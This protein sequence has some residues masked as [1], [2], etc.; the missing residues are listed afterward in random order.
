M[1]CH[2]SPENARQLEAQQLRLLY[3]QASLALIGNVINALVVA[4]TLWDVVPHV[5][6]LTWLVVIE[7]ITLA[8][9][10]LARWYKQTP[11]PEI[12]QQRWRKLFLLGSCASGVLWGSAGILLFPDSSRIHQMFLMFMLGGMAAGG[13]GV[14]SAIKSVYLSYCLSTLLPILFRVFLNGGELSYIMGFVLFFFICIVLISGKHVHATIT[15]A[16]RLRVANLDLIQHLSAA[17]EQAEHMNSELAASH[18]ALSESHER[19]RQMFERNHA[20]QLLIDPESGQIMDANTAAAIFYGGN[21]EILK[22]TNITNINTLPREQVVAEMQQAVREQRPYFQFRHRL[23]SGAIR[24]VEVHASPVTVGGKTLVYSIIH[25]VTARK[26]AEAALRLSEERFR[27]LIEHA[28]D[29]ITIVDANGV[30]AY[31]SPSLKRLLGY[32]EESVIGKPTPA[33][34]HPADEPTV[35]T[36]FSA[37]VEEPMGVRAF[38]FR[39]RHRDG[40]WRTFESIAQNL[41]DDNA[42]AGVVLNSRDITERKEIERL[43][44]DLVATVSH[45]LRTPLTSLRGFA[46]LLLTR[47]F[48]Q[49]KQRQFLSVIVNEATR[50]TN[51]IN[52]FLDLQRI[53]SGRQTYN[54]ETLALSPLLHDA[55]SVF[56]GGDNTRA[57]RVEIDPTLP[58]VHGDADRIRQV[59]ANL[60]SNAVKFSPEGGAV[61]VRA[62][63]NGEE[64]TIEVQDRGI[65]I[66]PEALPRLFRKFYRAD[67]T[68]TRR[69]GGTGLG[70]SLVKQIIEA[71]GGRVWVESELHV[72]SSFF[73][74]LPIATQEMIAPETETAL[75]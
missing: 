21:R 53:E 43:K 11:H 49:T 33:F 73:F 69:I 37:L 62:H 4:F 68:E 3:T 13:V 15:E 10:A 24:D 66:S 38:E 72:G 27:S 61:T 36:A 40:S 9:L 8:R 34:I 44:D 2:L 12:H 45:E 5:R 25:D 51:L 18:T 17:K 74:S 29:L 50:L 41:L 71:H 35:K 57:M 70:L 58:L 32:T 39:I 16:L 42:V 65:G 7:T 52:D 63:T 28:S 6:L 19:Y 54:F 48:P 59:L 31:C 75:L 60:F 22:Q 56:S 26:Q 1:G 20:V 47:E 46:E 14:L 55:A 23:F 30:V 64:V 67:N